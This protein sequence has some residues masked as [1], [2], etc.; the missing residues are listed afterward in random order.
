[1][2]PAID[3]LDG[4]PKDRKDRKLLYGI[5]FSGAYDPLHVIC[6]ARMLQANNCFVS[7]Y[8]SLTI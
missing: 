5:S 8:Q 6:I 4:I 2:P 1:M 3:S 7:F